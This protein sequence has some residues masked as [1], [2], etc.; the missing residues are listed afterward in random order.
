[1]PTAAKTR[2]APRRKR[3]LAAHPFRDAD[4]LALLE[5]RARGVLSLVAPTAPARADYGDD[6][7]SDG[8]DDVEICDGVALVRIEGP[9]MAS[10]D[11]WDCCDNYDAIVRRTSAAL[12]SPDVSSVVMAFD[13]PGGTVAGLFDA[14]RSLR[15]AKAA[16]GKRMVA[17]TAAGCYSAAYGLASTCDEVVVSDSAG[18]GSIGVIACL[19]SRAKELDAEGI[20]VAVVASGTEKTDGHPALPIGVGARKRLTERVMSLAG[21]FSAEVTAGRP[22]LTAAAITALDA[23]VRYGRDAVGAGL[24]DRVASLADLVASLKP[25]PAPKTQ[26]RT[27][28]AARSAAQPA[29]QPAT[30]RNKTMDELTLAALAALT[31]KVEPSEMLAA[32]QSMKTRAEAHDALTAKLAAA[33]ATVAK[34]SGDLEVAHAASRAAA[35]AAEKV[36]RAGLLSTAK[37]EGKWSASLD[38]WLASQS[39]EQLRAWVPV[40][41]RVVPQGE[42]LPPAEGGHRGASSGASAEVS[43]AILKAEKEGWLALSAAEKGAITRHDPKIADSLRARTAR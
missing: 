31:G 23:G 2:R 14:M 11:W 37:A 22:A 28:F 29:A 15:A 1:M 40:A 5:A 19:I 3:A 16:S 7:D 34:L 24:A 43:A 6:E 33:D 39:I 26:T 35:E 25:P 42:H 21:M 41:P 32:L 36:E 27:P 13:S 18:V 10:A 8:L 17:H 20:E 9:L 4:A 38:G 30:T 12:A